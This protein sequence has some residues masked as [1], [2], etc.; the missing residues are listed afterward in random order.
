MT[1]DA[2]D[3]RS[4][5]RVTPPRSGVVIFRSKQPRSH[6][7]WAALAACGYWVI[8]FVIMGGPFW[9]DESVPMT[10]AAAFWLFGGPFAMAI[11]ARR[12]DCAVAARRGDVRP[13]HV[14]V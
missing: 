7:G 5:D 9:A 11:A 8:L 6:V 14:P 10:I 3:D 12:A 1:S 4:E 13:L 2:S